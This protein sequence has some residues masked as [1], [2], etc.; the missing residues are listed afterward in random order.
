MDDFD[1]ED[2]DASAGRNAMKKVRIMIF[3]KQKV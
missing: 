3:G 2:D 1:I